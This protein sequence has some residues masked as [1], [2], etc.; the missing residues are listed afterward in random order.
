M[1][2]QYKCDLADAVSPHA[3]GNSARSPV[4]RRNMKE[5]Q[6]EYPF[7]AAMLPGI[8]N[9]L[10]E[11]KRYEATAFVNP[12]AFGELDGNYLPYRK[13]NL[14]IARFWSAI[15]PRIVNVSHELYVDGHYSTAAEKAVKEVE[16]RLR[17]KFLELKTGAAV[18]AKIGDVIGALM[19]ENGAFKF[20]DTTTTSGRDYRHGIQFLFE[21]IMAAYRN[22]AAHANLQYEK[23]EAMEQIMLA[24]QLM[25]VLEKPL[26]L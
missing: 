20:C 24:S 6:T 18:P 11:Q 12:V 19:S 16:S 26:Q 5:T 3:S 22:P 13:Q 23:R 14:S 15:H 1:D 9:I 8:A 7:Y 10:F 4:D 21:G 25:Y 17:E 2:R